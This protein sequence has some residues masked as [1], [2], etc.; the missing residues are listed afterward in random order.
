MFRSSSRTHLLSMYVCLF[1]HCDWRGV[2][3]FQPRLAILICFILGLSGCM[4]AVEK[5]VVP[6]PAQKVKIE[7]NGP[8]D[9]DIPGEYLDR[10]RGLDAND[11]TI[12]PVFLA[13][14]GYFEMEG[15]E[16]QAL[17]FLDRAAAAFARKNE[18]SGEA[19]VF[20]RKALLLM[21]A[22]RESDTLDLLRKGGERWTTPPLRA[23]PE[24]LEGRYALEQGDFTRAR[25]LLRRSLQ[26][27]TN[28]Q[29]D[30]HLL[31][32]KR[33]TELA[34]GMATVLFDHAPRL[35]A[36]YGLPETPG[37]KKSRA[38]EGR[39]HLNTALA[40]N[41]ELRQ[42]RIGELIPAHMF[43]RCQADA[44][45]FLGLD[46]G[47][48]GS[49]EE[50]F[51]H[52]GY[53]AELSRRSDFRE[54]EIRSLI[55]LG[56]LG[57]GGGNRVGGGQAAEMLRER[58]DRYRVAQYRIWARL[59]L[60]RYDGEEGR[61]GE[62]IAALQEADAIVM[63]RRSGPDAGMFSQICRRQRR[64]V[65]ENLV[66]LLAGAGRV[67]DALTAAEKAKAL[68]TVDLLSG[69]D[70]G[71][72]D[73]GREL[74][75]RETDIGETI[76]FLQRRIMRISGDAA[77]RRL[78][79]RIIGLE[80]DYRDLLSR[81]RAED[82]KLL[83]LVSVRG[84]EPSSLQGLLGTDTTL[85]DYFATD[86][87]LYVWAISRERIHMERLPLTREA[88]RSLVFS[89]LDAIHEKSKRRIDNLSRKAYDLLLKPVIPFVSG[90]RI[91][92]IPDD[93]LNYFPFAAMNYRG[94][95]LVEGFS[96]FHLSGAG[97]LEQAMTGTAP[98]GLRVLAFGDPDLK[99][100]TLDL[101]NAVGELAQIRKRIGNTTL[102]TNEQATEANVAEMIAGY[103]ILHFAVRGQFYPDAPL[104]SGLLL[105]PAA[106]QDGTLSVLEIFRLHYPGR[107]VVLSGCEPL[108][109]EDP[110]GKSF[111]AL[112]QAFLYAGSSS[113]IS[114][115]W[116][117]D[118]RAA[119]RLVDIFYRELAKKE[120]LSDSLR[121][122]QLRLIREGYSPYIWAA[123][124][125]T[126]RY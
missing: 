111:S 47:M 50:S 64:V 31:Q 16:G 78:L 117:V 54:G 115:L 112:Q 96:L 55:F 74:L 79:E 108:P 126:G 5:A 10:L 84:I 106:D 56:E 9:P 98:S 119:S 123:F 68:V 104:R 53:A 103:D 49:M 81:L 1:H 86:D 11:W 87:S 122:A 40:I 75:R 45:A 41:R 101:H 43:E 2:M 34:A 8:Y 29:K 97:M 76:G 91:G 105:T 18:S 80:N 25:E 48:R 61:F 52:L 20:C 114:T 32:L 118:D 102:L 36:A 62:A 27:N 71:G 46:M 69:H 94:K 120:S 77:T 88:L 26:D 39:T 95:F 60:A 72:S 44:Y 3:P 38:G 28:F 14:S 42:T 37:A 116:L 100:E 90:E 85:F 59:L 58:A 109:E 24:Y 89:V 15:E 33:D 67:G 30:L 107:A 22:G 124:V 21:H 17:H 63:S 82:E 12:P 19:L 113:V 99:N 65:Y 92:F 23:F 93:C 125:L 121:A 7:L 51:H 4:K 66:A 6:P 57:F 110:E 73:A 13:V 35:L 83:S 70:I